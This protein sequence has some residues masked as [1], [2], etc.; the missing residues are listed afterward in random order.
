MAWAVLEQ[1]SGNYVKARVLFEK[2]L[3]INPSSVA[4]LQAF[5]NMERHLENWSAA[6]RLLRKALKLE[7]ENAAVL[8]EAAFVE[9]S[10]GNTEVADRLFVL[11][12]MADKRT[13]R[14]TNKIFASRKEVMPRGVDRALERSE[15]QKLSTK[16][17]EDAFKLGR[18]NLSTNMV[19]G[20]KSYPIKAVV[21]AAK[22]KQEKV[23]RHS[24]N[25]KSKEREP[26]NFQVAIIAMR[27][28]QRELRRTRGLFSGL[29]RPGI[30]SNPEFQTA[31]KGIEA[32]LRELN[33]NSEMEKQPSFSAKQ[34]ECAAGV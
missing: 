10:L 5:A 14:V 22:T 28:K 2:C 4:S 21:K 1:T 9:N 32:K 6:Q 18:E 17:T 8:M 30:K 26:A 11:A 15:H 12:G 31:I 33:T 20:R 24:S 16:A 34:A 29:K 23:K 7:P 27:S 25:L 13:S 19:T 3:E